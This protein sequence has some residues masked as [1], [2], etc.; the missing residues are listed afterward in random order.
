MPEARRRLLARSVSEYQLGD[1][2][3]E[4]RLVAQ[5]AEAFRASAEEVRMVTDL[6]FSEERE[7]S[8]LLACAVRRDRRAN[9]RNHHFWV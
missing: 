3:G 6:W 1:G 2:G 9:F 8:R 7:H 5:D 4:C